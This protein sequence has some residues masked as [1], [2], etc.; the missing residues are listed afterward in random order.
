MFLKN[1]A[2][3]VQQAKVTGLGAGLPGAWGP[4]LVAGTCSPGHQSGLLLHRLPPEKS[5]LVGGRQRGGRRLKRLPRTWGPGGKRAPSPA[6][7]EKRRRFSP[8]FFNT[9]N[10][11]TIV[12]SFL[13]GFY[14]KSKKNLITRRDKSN[15]F[16]C[17]FSRNFHKNPKKIQQNPKIQN[18]HRF[19]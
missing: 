13:F 10:L 4:G 9:G 7:R 8:M 15:Y 1:L 16:Q 11:K 2:K 19:S 5:L 14:E 12:F 17:C 18:F 6:L 3:S